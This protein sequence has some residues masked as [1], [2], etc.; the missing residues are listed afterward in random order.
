MYV[1]QAMST[2]VVA[3]APDEPATRAARDLIERDITG[4][5]VV[6]ADGHVLGVVSE[7]DL[8]RAM[9][10]GIDLQQTPVE[11]VMDRRPLFVGPDTDLCTAIDLMEEWRVRRLPVCVG[12]R[13]VGIVSRRDILAVLIEQGRSHYTL[14][15]VG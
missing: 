5:P 8:L 4:L 13:L 11:T 12:T 2:H 6:D 7:L 10:S 3:I 9:R 14:M 1:Y 15:R